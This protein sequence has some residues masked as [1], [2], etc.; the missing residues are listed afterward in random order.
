MRQEKDKGMEKM[1]DRRRAGQGR[2]GGLV[3]VTAILILLSPVASLSAP[4][5]YGIILDLGII[6]TDNVFLSA[7]NLAVG[8]T[9]ITVVPE[10]FFTKDSERLNA[11]L[12]YRPEAYFYTSLDDVD[13]VFHS[14]DASLTTMLARD[15]FFLKIG[16]VNFQSIT[17]P[18]G[19]FPTSNLPVSGNRVDTRTFEISPYWEQRIG[20]ANLLAEVGYRGADYDD[21]LYQSHNER[22]GLLQLN[23]FES[24]QGLAWG[25]DYQYRRMEY[26]ISTPWDFQRAAAN[27][28]VWV[29]RGLRVFVIGGAETSLDDLYTSNMDEDFWE[30]GFQYKPNQRMDLELAAGERSYGTSFRG[31]FTYTLRRGDISITYDEGPSTRG[32]LVF[33]RRSITD[34]DNLDNILDEPG[35]TDRFLRRRAEFQ[36]NIELSKSDLTLRV[37]SEEREQRTTADGIELDDENYSGAALRWSWSVGTKT[38][39]GLGTDISRRDQLGREDELLRA[40]IDFKY[41]F[42]ER[43]SVR[44][45]GIHSSQDG[46]ESDDYDYDEN[47]IRL[48]LRTEF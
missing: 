22:Y 2:R 16:A 28:G 19:Q 33:E 6:R 1:N 37:F 5:D 17:T 47:Q 8:E 3:H 12:R 10:F 46:V 9:V 27:L 20:Q 29:N 48:M 40:Q 44:L 36:M 43:L 42:S 15:K 23:N 31:N 39:F 18:D 34:T 38:T 7:D 14:V 13:D 35:A 11:N 26:D 30:A 25:L 21:D 41:D 4:A 24:Q 45:E 32:E